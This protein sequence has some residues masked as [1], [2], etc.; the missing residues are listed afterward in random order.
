MS[1]DQH[2]LVS[3]SNALISIKDNTQDIIT[4]AI[5]MHA[6]LIT[7]TTTRY[8]ECKRTH[9]IRGLTVLSPFEIF[10]P[11]SNKNFEEEER[12][13]V[14]PENSQADNKVPRTGLEGQV[15]RSKENPIDSWE[16]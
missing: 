4:K 15:V 5:H 1:K 3:T 16:E 9:L 8:P 6:T 11:L 7:L 12:I 14:A 10:A 13:S 2:C